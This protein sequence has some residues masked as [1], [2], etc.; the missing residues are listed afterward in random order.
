MA[1]KVIVWRTDEPAV[2]Q[3]ATVWH[4]AEYVVAVWDGKYWVDSD[5][6]LMPGGLSWYI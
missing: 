6:R 5:G 4:F 1:A 2:G 3:R